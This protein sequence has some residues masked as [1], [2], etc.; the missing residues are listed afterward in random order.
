[1]YAF[2][3]N[4]DS[5]PNANIR[6]GWMTLAT[7]CDIL[8]RTNK[9]M[10]SY[11]YNLILAVKRIDDTLNRWHWMYKNWSRRWQCG[12]YN[13]SIACPWFQGAHWFSSERALP[14]ENSTE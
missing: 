11:I 8:F 9:I 10:V 3:L 4:I 5:H 6:F 13:C 7:F 12:G 14:K 2:W 1:M